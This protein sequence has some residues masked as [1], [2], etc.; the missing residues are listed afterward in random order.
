MIGKQTIII[1]L[2]L[3]AYQ[4]VAAQ[5]AVQT[6]GTGGITPIGEYNNEGD[7]D[8]QNDEDEK[9]TKPEKKQVPSI[10]RTWQIRN[11][12][13]NFEKAELDT[14]LNFYHIYNPIFKDN[15]LPEFTGNI[16][17]AYLSSDFFNR[18]PKT[19][20]YFYHSYEDYSEFPGTIK[21]FNTTTP[22]TLLDYSQS[23]NRNTR[24]ETRFNVYH[25]QNANKNFNFGFFYNQTK[26]TGH[27]QYQENRF[28]NI[29][30]NT[31][32]I[33]DKFNS[34]GTIIFNRHKSE[35]NGGLEPGQDLNQYKETETYLVNLVAANSALRNNTISLIN[36]YRLGKYEDKEDSLGNI[37]K[38]FRPITGIIHQI[39]YFGNRRLYTDTDPNLDFY[40]TAIKDSTATNDTVMYNR[41]TNI[42]QLK[43][44]ESPDRKY[45]FSKRAY[46]GYD[47]ITTKMVDIDSTYLSKDKMHNTFVGG[48]ISRDQ[49]EFWRWNAQGK[50]YLTGYR[51][52][53]TELSAYIFKPMKIGKDTTS[54]FLSGELNTIVPDYFQQTYRSNFYNW[55]NHFD[56][57]T[58]M[59]IKSRI[60]SSEHK[61]TVGFNY[62]LIGNYVFNNADA[63]P[64]QGSREMLILSA[65][66]NKD[67]ES[68]HWLLRAQVLWQK[69]NQEDYLHLPQLTGYLSVNF[70]LLI[71]KVMHSEFGIDTRYNTAYYA[72]AYDPATARYYWQNQQKIGNFPIID[73]HANLKLKR[74][75]AFFQWL[76]A[77]AGILNG[78]YWAA[79]DYP[80]YRRTFRLGIAW[81]FYD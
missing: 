41:F 64:Q 46:I 5:S 51:S 44:Y 9:D 21:F 4:R 69:T 31:S 48:A 72:D 33:S 16:G 80:F 19:D 62:A 75:R 63:L 55:R 12:G 59:I 38:V 65:Y 74:T 78:N 70:K 15:I 40:P 2:F 43:F 71:S 35:E 34:H 79:P 52:G 14:S 42:V 73:L 1:I 53:Q 20:F 81:S 10:I 7:E 54:L 13:A 25:T 26:S 8:Q 76:N 29:G 27:Y 28:H 61:L 67:I 47:M 23:E 77:G 24:N 11:Y 32:Y 58:E 36:E 68:K 66:L 3:I 6:F 18:N 45:T 56:N 60:S 22:Y 17:G 50:F 30:F 49:G 37:D 57:T 39:E